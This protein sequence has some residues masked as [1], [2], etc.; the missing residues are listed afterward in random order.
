MSQHSLVDHLVEPQPEVQPA[1][2]TYI[3]SIMSATEARKTVVSKRASKSAYLKLN[4]DEPW[5]TMQAQLLVKIDHALRPSQI[6]YDQYEIKFY[7]TR[8]L[9]KPGLSLDS[10]TDYNLMIL[11]ARK[12][13]DLTINITI[14]QL[15]SDDDK[16]NEAEVEEVTKPKKKAVRVC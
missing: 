9:P 11:K 4:T 2:V 6:Q 8:V 14:V 1:E 12:L 13:R 3:I 16:E 10:E 15:V 7:I 5:E